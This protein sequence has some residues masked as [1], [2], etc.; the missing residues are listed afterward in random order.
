MLFVERCAMGFR[1]NSFYHEEMHPFIDAMAGV[2]T[3]AGNRSRRPDV[4]DYILRSQKQDFDT[5]TEYLK[6]VSLELVQKRRKN[7]TDK[8]DLLNAMLNNRDPKLGVGLTDDS[9]V[10]NMI[11]FLVA[12]VYQKAREEVDNV[13][14]TGA[15][16]VDHMSQLPYLT[17]C[18]RETLR[19]HPTAPAFGVSAK[20]DDVIGGKYAVKQGQAIVF[21]L[22]K[23]HTDPAVYGPDAADFKPERMLD[24]PFSKLPQNSW[25]PF[26]NGVRGCIGRPFAWQ[27][28][29]LTFALLMQIFDFK[30]TNPS[31]LLKIKQTLTI[32]PLDFKMRATMRN[33]SLLE[34]L[35]QVSGAEP[36][37][38]PDGASATGRKQRDSFTD[39]NAK[40]P[41]VHIFYGSNT[42]TCETLANNLASSAQARGY[43]A[44]VDVLDKATDKLSTT[45]PTVVITASYEGEAPDN[46]GQ[47][48]SW[49]KSA[50]QSS[51]ENVKYAVFGVGNRDWVSTYQQIPKLVDYKLSKTGA[52]RLTDRGIVD[53]AD[54]EIFNVF[55]DW[56]DEQLWPSIEKNFGAGAEVKASG[57][58][59][60]SITVAKDVRTTKLRQDV[61]TAMVVESR[62]LTAPG[63]AA[64]RH[65]QLKLPTGM[66]YKAGDYLAVLPINPTQ[67][68]RRAMARFELTWDATL[69]IKEKSQTT[70]P[71]G[72]PISA[73]DVFSSYVELGQ[74]ATVK[75]II[76]LSRLVDDE[77]ARK[78]LEEAC[79]PQ[80][81]ELIQAKNVSLLQLLE[82][83]P[84]ANYTLGQ[85]L[86]AVP[87]MRTRQ[88]SISSSPLH[89]SNTASL[90]FSVLDAPAHSAAAAANG[91]RFLGVASNYLAQVQPRDHVHISLR[92]SH[93]GFRL[94]AD[95]HAP[96]MM[97]CAGTGLAPFRAFVQ[98]RA[99]KI[100]AA[101]VGAALGPA[102]LFYGCNAPDEDDMY[103]AEFDYWESI[104]AVDVRRAYTFAP[105]AS[106]GCK[107]V[108]H[109]V[110]HDR[111]E[112]VE[113]FKADARM[114]ICGAGVVGTAIMD[115]ALRMY[116]EYTGCEEEE[117]KAWFSGL[118]GE[119]T[120][121][122]PCFGLER[123]GP[124]FSTP[125]LGYV[126]GGF[127]QSQFRLEAFA[128]SSVAD[129]RSG[130]G[131]ALSSGAPCW[132]RRKG[133]G[134]G[135]CSRI[136]RGGE[137]DEQ[138]ARTIRR[139][140]AAATRDSKMVPEWSVV[141]TNL[142]FARKYA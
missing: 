35:G 36:G 61:Q 104:G 7:P 29:L 102:I 112:L 67:S 10:D 69:T 68:V 54:G 108:Q 14:G 113:L 126:G 100:E 1:F 5:K 27:E 88:Y 92:P 47:F 118:R 15:V 4:A 86:E 89:D 49:L 43:G 91:Q 33:A 82:R 78:E 6:R 76:E 97:A 110:W 117:A 48:V 53:V 32:K 23:V 64:K 80:Y 28:A 93:A 51:L 95:D 2:L 101:G 66:N 9:I 17:A 44:K 106:E 128:V 135:K 84:T 74:P 46:A 121:S 60:L 13:I 134:P 38:A 79:G 77:Q 3:E 62:L 120:E 40:G 142:L 99:T 125:A 55:D 21:I 57:D 138:I 65:L 11:T 30:A 133:L 52:T 50:S 70:I 107:F 20:E 75:Q 109:R 123:C 129:Q 94:P 127:S 124:C 111:A 122:V 63:K 19:L 39:S 87:A 136:R 73:N 141:A 72:R 56:V 130:I 31:Y 81:K 139:T 8:K 42:G 115:T 18:L 22:T 12:E 119:S 137:H 26:G 103:R 132:A 105:E 131:S 96:I 140:D 41:T 114:Y 16:T 24:E 37:Y 116:R 90:T 83:Y 25:K 85:F 98:E 71:T 59:G 34:N 58:P 45:E